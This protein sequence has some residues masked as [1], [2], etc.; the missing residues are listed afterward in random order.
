MKTISTAAN[1][2]ITLTITLLDMSGCT[3]AAVEAAISNLRTL[4]KQASAVFDPQRVALLLRRKHRG[5]STY[6]SPSSFAL[7][8]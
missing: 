3:H 7:L 1:L 2:D 4:M 5:F 8:Y 6:F